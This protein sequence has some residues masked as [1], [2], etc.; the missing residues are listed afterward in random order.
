MATEGNIAIGLT[1]HE[2]RVSAVSVKST[3][4]LQLPVVLVG[5]Q[6]QKAVDTIS[7]LY[8][9]CSEAQASASVQAIESAMGLIAD[10]ATCCV[11]QQLLNMEGVREHAWRIFLDW[12]VLI[13][14]EPEKSSLA[15]LMRL[16]SEWRTLLNPDHSAYR[17]GASA[18]NPQLA[19]L[20]AISRPCVRLLEQSVYG[21]PVAQ[22]L[23]NDCAETL[24]AW[25]HAGESGAARFLNRLECMGWSALGC[26][27]MQPLPPVSGALMQQLLRDEEPGFDKFCPTLA[28]SPC[29]TSPFSRL[30][31]HPLMVSLTARFGAGLLTRF[32][33]VLLEVAITLRE[34]QDGIGEPLTQREAITPGVGSVEAAR[35][36]LIHRVDLNGDKIGSYQILAPTEWNFHPQ[37]AIHQG[38]MNL[39]AKNDQ[40]LEQQARLLVCAMD[41]CVGYTL[42]VM[43]H[44]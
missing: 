13:G 10:G 19:S 9:I 2:G 34:I 20:E 32:S 1:I 38:M 36:R 7:L 3:R 43:K 42:E 15:E 30:R 18:V 41:P 5:Q 27:Q 16:S 12:P 11:R 17:I 39:N 29:E 8:R 26:S 40:E 33:A 25:V 44:A 31:D 37:G 21:M 35:G 22:W 23:R 14:E 28:G 6:A 24:L 4:P